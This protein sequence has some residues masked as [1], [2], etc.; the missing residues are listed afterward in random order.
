VR[1]Y[2]PTTYRDSNIHK[3][4]SRD[5]SDD[6]EELQAFRQETAS[7]PRISY[8]KDDLQFGGLWSKTILED[9]GFWGE[10]LVEVEGSGNNIF[11]VEALHE[12]GCDNTLFGYA[13]DADESGKKL[14][15]AGMEIL[16]LEFAL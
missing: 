3:F 2:I 15:N 12:V 10:G 5:F 8:T 11:N 6:F 14:S 1:I 16:E 7:T 4:L 9:V 13:D